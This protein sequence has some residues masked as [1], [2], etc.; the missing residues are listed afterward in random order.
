MRVGLADFKAPNADFKATDAD[1]D[2]IAR[3]S[4]RGAVDLPADFQPWLLLL[5]PFVFG[6]YFFRDSL[7][8]SYRHLPR[9][10]KSSIDM[11]R[12]IIA[13]NVSKMLPKMQVVI[14]TAY[15]L[16]NQGSNPAV[17]DFV[18]VI[19]ICFPPSHVAPVVT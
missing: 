5:F 8:T 18:Q 3:R 15:N 16:D 9:A 2:Q 1:A 11:D 6:L 13:P 19:V 17:N 7:I 14:V 10:Q 12:F 4:I